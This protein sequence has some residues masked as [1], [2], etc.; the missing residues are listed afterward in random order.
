MSA[1]D[2]PNSFKHTL[3]PS[4]RPF[5]LANPVR[6]VHPTADRRVFGPSDF[7]LARR[8]GRGG[9][10]SLINNSYPGPFLDVGKTVVEEEEGEAGPLLFSSLA[11]RA[12]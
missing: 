4:K 8:G 9:G 3:I 7:N 2:S 5:S 10:R 1:E 12:K 6:L 11:A